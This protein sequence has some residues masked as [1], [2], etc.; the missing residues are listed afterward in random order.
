MSELRVL[1][2]AVAALASE[3]ETA[4]LGDEEWYDH[5]WA[6]LEPVIDA[7]AERSFTDLKRFGKS[8]Q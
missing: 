6:L 5:L 4:E 1:R 3:P 2:E 7:R 8:T